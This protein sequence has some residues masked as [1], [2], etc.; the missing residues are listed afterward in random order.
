MVESLHGP[1]GRFRTAP[2]ESYVLASNSSKI[3]EDR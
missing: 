1:K 2:V 3:E